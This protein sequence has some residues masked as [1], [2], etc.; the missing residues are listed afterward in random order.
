M[1]NDV[2]TLS[3]RSATMSSAEKAFPESRCVGEPPAAAD[4]RDKSAHELGARGGTGTPNDIEAEVTGLFQCHVSALSRFA[5]LVTNDRTLV[6]EA[7]Q[8][9]FLRYFMVRIDAQRIENPR[10]WLFRVVKNYLLD[11]RRRS[12]LMPAVGLD[13]AEHL[14]DSRQDVAARYEQTDMF[15]RA[16]SSL[17]P[18]ERQCVQ[19]RLGGLAYDE[20]AVILEI[21]PGTVA[22]LLARGLKKFRNA[23]LL[24][25]RS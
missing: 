16:L 12:G 17:S 24:P 15:R 3:R 23:G 6:P 5:A 22:A 18:R 4:R 20:I 7:I 1:Y 19:L 2:E 8:E 10:A 25:R 11:R 9:A 21:R 14:A 13:A